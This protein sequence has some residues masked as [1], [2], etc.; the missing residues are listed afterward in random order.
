MTKLF[1]AVAAATTLLA[2]PAFAGSLEIE[3]VLSDPVGGRQDSTGLTAEYTDRLYKDIDFGLEFQANQLENAGALSNAA[4]AKL[5]TDIAGPA[6]VTLTPFVEVGRAFGQGDNFSFW[7][8]ELQA[9]KVIQGPVTGVVGIRH[10]EG[11][12]TDLL[13]ET[14][15][16]AGLQ[17]AVTERQAVGVTYYRTRG[18][19]DRDSVGISY[20]VK[21]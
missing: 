3:G 6:G 12:D 9:S 11:F 5:S 17:Y 2:A 13:D 16:A 20:T 15:L 21:F 7:G 10:R 14:R 8:A 1:V 18:S 4:V 19:S